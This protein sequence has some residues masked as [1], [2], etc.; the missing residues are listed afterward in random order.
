MCSSD[1]EDIRDAYP[2]GISGA[3]A[4]WLWKRILETLAWV[5]ATGWIHGGLLPGHLLVHARDHGVRLIGFSRAVRGPRPLPAFTQGAEAFYPDAVWRGGPAQIRTDLTMSARSLLWLI[6]G[7]Q[8]SQGASTVPAALGD[9]LTQSASEDAGGHEDALTLLS[10]LDRAA[11]Q[12]YGAPKY[13]P[14]EMPGWA[15]ASSET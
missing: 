15:G 14:F 13:V 7:G 10:E 9:L 2:K 3:A 5:H 4:I 11:R 12:A 8:L 1:L 6:G